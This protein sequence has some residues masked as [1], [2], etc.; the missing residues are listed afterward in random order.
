ME[1]PD[2]ENVMTQAQVIGRSVKTIREADYL[3]ADAKHAFFGEIWLIFLR[4]GC[5][6]GLISMIIPDAGS[7]L[8]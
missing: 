4:S 6:V 8:S 2:L 1:L 3:K 5:R 7:F